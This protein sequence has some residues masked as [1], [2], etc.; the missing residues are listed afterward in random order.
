MCTS[1]GAG[2]ASILMDNIA[3]I[4]IQRG[5]RWKFTHKYTDANSIIFQISPSRW[6]SRL[7]NTITIGGSI[8]PKSLM[9]LQNTWKI[10]G[11]TETKTDENTDYI[12]MIYITLIASN[13]VIV[14]LGY[15][16]YKKTPT[17][18]IP[19]LN[20]KCQTGI[21]RKRPA[22]ILREIKAQDGNP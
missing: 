22:Y 6:N 8:S 12:T 15:L 17:D 9:A 7:M 19:W 5:D 14:G 11:N 10:K 18:A 4:T 21:Q 1:C 13:I 3:T 16:I 2:T 20:D